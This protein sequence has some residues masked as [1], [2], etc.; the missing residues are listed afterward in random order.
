MIRRD[1]RPLGMILLALA[2]VGAAA[3]CA[4]VQAASR[5]GTGFHPAIYE[6]DNATD[7]A[8]NFHDDQLGTNGAYQATLGWD[9][10]SGFGTAVLTPLITDIDH[11]N[12]APIQGQ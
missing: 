11:G 9:D 3:T 7:H 6:R 12:T 8:R 5:G 10:V 1:I 2:G 4:P